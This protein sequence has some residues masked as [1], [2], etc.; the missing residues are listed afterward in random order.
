MKLDIPEIE[1]EDLH[2]ESKKSSFGFNSSFMPGKTNPMGGL[3]VSF[4]KSKQNEVVRTTFG[5]AE[6]I[7]TNSDISGL[8]RDLGAAHKKGSKKE[9]K[10]GIQL[11]TL[12]LEAMFQQAR[13][14]KSFFTALGT[15]VPAQLEGQAKASEVYRRLIAAGASPQEALYLASRPSLCQKISSGQVDAIE[16]LALQRIAMRAKMPAEIAVKGSAAQQHYRELLALGY[17]EQKALD[18]IKAQGQAAPATTANPPPPKAKVAPRTQGAIEPPQEKRPETAKVPPKPAPIESKPTAVGLH[19]DD[20]VSKEDF[21]HGQKVIDDNKAY[22]G[23]AFKNISSIQDSIAVTKGNPGLVHAPAP[24]SASQAFK[25]QKIKQLDTALEKLEKVRKEVQEKANTSNLWDKAKAA[26]VISKIDEGIEDLQTAIDTQNKNIKQEVKIASNLAAFMLGAGATAAVTKNPKLAALGGM[27]TAET[28]DKL[29]EK[30]EN[31]KFGRNLAK[32]VTD[33][34]VAFIT[35]GIKGLIWETGVAAVGKGCQVVSAARKGV[36]AAI[37]IKPLVTAAEANAVLN[38]EK[39]AASVTESTIN[40]L[41]QE[42]NVAESVLEAAT[43]PNPLNVVEIETTYGMSKQSINIKESKLYLTEIGKKHPVPLTPEELSIVKNWQ[44]MRKGPLEKLYE[45]DMIGIEEK[46]FKNIEKIRNALR[47][48][49]T[50]DDLAAILKERRDIKIFDPQGNLM[51]HIAEYNITIEGVKNRLQTLQKRLTYLND[52]AKQ[53]TP[54][55]VKEK[56]A[57]QETISE[58]SKL[59]I[60]Y[61]NK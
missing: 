47:D 12:D 43:T 45:L 25:A 6:E 18:E 22:C 50:P 46:S 2:L 8:N 52:N 49:T 19:P 36:G 39:S 51:D 9:S 13:S 35:G 41:K 21:E 38:A 5:P 28:S 37:E 44:E 14:V 23:P 53:V 31:G 59:L 27:A 20:V 15:E 42:V 4:D 55:V 29:I 7:K 34:A 11:P 57:I 3:G 48:H 16:G 1:F 60:D 32:D 17:T 54:N 24:I 10:G 61:K 58:A 33:L 56:Q 26:Y 40:T 30:F